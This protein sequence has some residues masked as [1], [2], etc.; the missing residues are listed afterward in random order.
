AVDGRWGMGLLMDQRCPK[1]GQVDGAD[2]GETWWSALMDPCQPG[3]KSLHIGQRG[4]DGSWGK[5][6][7][8][9]RVTEG[10]E[11][12][13]IGV[14]HLGGDYTQNRPRHRARDCCV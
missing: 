1:G 8:D 10:V 4:P 7:C 11:E 9:Q 2:P 5:I 12:G 6:T 13:H 14:Q 3:P